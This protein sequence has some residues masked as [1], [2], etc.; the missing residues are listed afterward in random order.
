VNTTRPSARLLGGL[1]VATLVLSTGV[2]A[3][4]STAKKKH[5]KPIVRHQTISYTGPCAGAVSVEGTGGTLNPGYCDTANLSVRSGEKYVTLAVKDSTGQPISGEL[6]TVKNGASSKSVGFCGSL[7]NLALAPG[8][9]SVDLNWG[10]NS[11]CPSGQ[12]T[13]GKIAVIYSSKA[14]K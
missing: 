4:A 13:Q 7:K 2:A 1:A 6:W 12:A 9:Y 5:A 3:E 10:V 8:S 14:Q 11:S